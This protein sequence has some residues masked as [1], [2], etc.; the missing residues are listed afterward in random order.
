MGWVLQHLLAAA[1]RQAAVPAGERKEIVLDGAGSVA[2]RWREWLSRVIGERPCK[3][4]LSWMYADICLR[5][6]RLYET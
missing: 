1:V 2:W 4:R 5:H 6:G 3:K